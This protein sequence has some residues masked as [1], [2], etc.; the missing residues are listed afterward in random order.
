MGFQ[1]ILVKDYSG[2]VI[3]WQVSIDGC[4]FGG[5]WVQMLINCWGRIKKVLKSHGATDAGWTVLTHD[6]HFCMLLV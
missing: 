4:S 2:S 1:M 5:S 3:D 6:A